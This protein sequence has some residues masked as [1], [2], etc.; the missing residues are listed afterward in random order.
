M[1]PLPRPLPADPCGRAAQ[2]WRRRSGN[3]HQGGTGAPPAHPDIASDAR[4]ARRPV[5][6]ALHRGRHTPRWE[7]W[8][9]G[10]APPCSAVWPHVHFVW[11]KET[12]TP[13]SE[14]IWYPGPAGLDNWA[15][16]QISVLHLI[17]HKVLLAL[18][19]A[20]QSFTYLDLWV[21]DPIRK[22]HRWMLRLL[23]VV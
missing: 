18:I 20:K 22:M 23:N 2:G 14:V 15:S 3:Q 7:R 9:G 6:P 8:R 19:L 17:L 4:S 12:Y 10:D 11:Y 16:F 21:I 13:S 5:G 1:T